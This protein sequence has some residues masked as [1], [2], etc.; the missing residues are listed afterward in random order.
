M[1]TALG[2]SA[3]A[4]GAS[5]LDQRSIAAWICAHIAQVLELEVSEID[6]QK[7]FEALGLDSAATVGM[8][9]DL[10]DWLGWRISPNLAYDYPSVHALSVCLADEAAHRGRLNAV[11]G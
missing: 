3:R 4:D 9:G 5:T 1:K 8:S 2:D 6:E 7:S 10:S 11:E